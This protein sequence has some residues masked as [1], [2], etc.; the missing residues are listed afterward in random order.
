MTVQERFWDKV[1]KAG[2]DDCWEWQA[3]IGANGYGSFRLEGKTLTAQRASYL[4]N[5]G[6]IPEGQIIRHKCDNRRC[7]NPDHLEVGTYSQ[8]NQDAVNRKRRRYKLSID[9]VRAIR[10]RLAE[11][12]KQR[13]LAQE[14]GVSQG[15]IH[16]INTHQTWTEG[17]RVA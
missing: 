10:Q 8:N 17:W 3:G 2:P 9:Q 5:V 13:P 4:F 14:Y 12:A 16:Q 7:V 15:L 6:E 11:G 1:N